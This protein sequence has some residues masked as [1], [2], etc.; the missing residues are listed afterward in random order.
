MTS[1]LLAAIGAHWLQRARP[2]LIAQLGAPRKRRLP[3]FAAWG[4]CPADNLPVTGHPRCAGCG[5]LAGPSH[6]VKALDRAGYCD[7]CAA[8]RRRGHAQSTA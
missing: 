5:F 8:R 1:G 4:L 7:Q 3:I 2:D 6:E